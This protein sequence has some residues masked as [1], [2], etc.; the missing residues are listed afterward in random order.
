MTQSSTTA[1]LNQPINWPALDMYGIYI[2]M[3]S[4]SN[5][6]GFYHDENDLND[7]QVMTLLVLDTKRVIQPQYLKITQ[8]HP[9]YIPSDASLPALYVFYQT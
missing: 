5:E 2:M 6:Y 4:F 7:K 8:L 9:L 3:R 1:T